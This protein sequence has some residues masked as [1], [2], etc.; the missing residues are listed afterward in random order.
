MIKNIKQFLCPHK[1]VFA[2]RKY[3]DFD[4]VE[5]QMCDDCGRILNVLKGFDEDIRG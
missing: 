4:F 2:Y 3:N 1:N 5:Y